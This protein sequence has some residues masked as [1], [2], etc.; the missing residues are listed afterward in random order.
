V[1]QLAQLRELG[2]EHG[3]GFHLSRPLTPEQAEALLECLLAELIEHPAQSA[4]DTGL[5]PLVRH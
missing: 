2:C 3:Q 1:S 4:F 5:M